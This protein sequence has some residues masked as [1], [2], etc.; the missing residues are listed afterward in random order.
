MKTYDDGL[1]L[2]SPI[3]SEEHDSFDRLTIAKNTAGLLNGLSQNNESSVIAYIGP[4]G[5]GKTSLINMTIKELE[6][7]KKIG[8]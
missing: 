3:E 5:C 6:K 7:D 4:W 1:W 8:G 2:D